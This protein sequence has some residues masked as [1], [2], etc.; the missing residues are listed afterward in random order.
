[1]KLRIKSATRLKASEVLEHD[2]VLQELR[3][4]MS[5]LLGKGMRESEQEDGN[6]RIVSFKGRSSAQD[7]GGN[8]LRRL[9][10]VMG[11]SKTVLTIH[12]EGGIPVFSFEIEN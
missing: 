1:M 10:Q 4:A 7:V 11:D 5:L 9:Q 6:R 8:D 12:V 3:N 2:K